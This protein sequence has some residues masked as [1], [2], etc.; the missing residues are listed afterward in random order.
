VRILELS[1]KLRSRSWSGSVA[2]AILPA[3]ILL[4][5]C[6]QSSLTQARTRLH[7]GDYAGAHRELTALAQHP[8][9]LSPEERREVNDD[10]CLTEFT[11]GR[12]QY[13]LREQQRVC[14][15]ASA[16]AGSQSPEVLTRVNA[17]MEQ[18]D[19][20]QIEAAIKAGDLA[21]AEA[22]VRD[23]QSMPG[24][25][26]VQVAEWSNRMWKLVEEKD[27]PTRSS[28]AATATAIAALKRE[29]RDVIKM[30]NNG[31]AEWM[32]K[33]ASIDGAPI[34]YDPRLDHGRLKLD[35]REPQLGSAALNL[36]KFAKINDAVVA[37]CGCD[38]RTDVGLG[39]SHL[40][41]YV[42]RLDTEN[43]RSEVL[44]LLSGENIG[45]RVSMR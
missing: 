37:R 18:A 44:I 40:P 20:V 41:A 14:T 38:A 42:V 27:N 28:K 4:A 26:Q 36:D 12:P 29:H 1:E 13:S 10:L 22:A 8:D 45:P 6:A 23:Y 5:G 24:A 35:V 2:R 3:L 15:E 17:A 34:I 43:R 16:E 33:T 9:K 19:D 7:A 25:N 11:I 32:V 39:S 21:A 30:S 31:F